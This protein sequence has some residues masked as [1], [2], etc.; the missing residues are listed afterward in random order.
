MSGPK[1]ARYIHLPGTTENISGSKRTRTK[2]K[3]RIGQAAA[4]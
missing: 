1:S 3:E 2:D 4:A